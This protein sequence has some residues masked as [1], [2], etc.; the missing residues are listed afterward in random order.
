MP[1][2]TGLSL[3]NVTIAESLALTGT[4]IAVAVTVSQRIRASLMSFHLFAMLLFV[5][6]CAA[7]LLGRPWSHL[8]WFAHFIGVF[9]LAQNAIGNHL[10]HSLGFVEVARQIHFV[11]KL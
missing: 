9:T 10:Y 3:G 6:A 7:F 8:W 4:G 1:A 11:A 2:P 5:Q